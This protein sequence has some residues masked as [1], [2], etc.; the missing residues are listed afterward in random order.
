MAEAEIKSGTA[1]RP[2]GTFAPGQFDRSIISVTERL[3][4][5]WPGLRIAIAL[6]RLVLARLRDDRP[7][8]VE[9][10]NLRL[11][12]YPCRNGCE[13]ALLF[14]PQMYERCEL[15]ALTTQIDKTKRAG[16]QFVF[17][18]LG[19]NV[20][21]FSLFV[22]SQAGADAKILAIEPEPENLRRFR[23]NLAANHPLPITVLDVALG[24]WA[25]EISLIVNRRDRGGTRVGRSGD[26]VEGAAVRARCVPLLTALDCCH[27]GAIDA[28]KIDIEGYEPEVLL[29]FFRDAPQSLWPNLLIIEDGRSGWSADLF[30]ELQ[31]RGYAQSARSRLNV[32][33]ERRECDIR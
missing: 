29:P 33:F 6:R 32:I 11:R 9:R 30:S 25:D 22:A 24:A 17:I 4:D 28:L 1:D 14:T 8:D 31:N 23:F 7:L 12:L 20:G 18:D 13:K 10:W 26:E 2:Y 3:P 16:R 21:L 27:I 5:N 19:A 15:S